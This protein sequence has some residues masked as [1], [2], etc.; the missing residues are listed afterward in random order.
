MYFFIDLVPE[1]PRT[2][3]EG[4]ALPELGKTW[5]PQAIPI[6]NNNHNNGNDNRH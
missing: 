5:V 2:A 3:Q 1:A 4:A 6:H